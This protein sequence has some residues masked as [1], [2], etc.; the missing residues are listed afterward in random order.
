MAI[1]NNNNPM[2]PSS[3]VVPPV[4]YNQSGA[5][6]GGGI[7]ISPENLGGA[8]KCLTTQAN[9]NTRLSQQQGAYLVK[10]VRL[11][12]CDATGAVGNQTGTIKYGRPGL[13]PEFADAVA[14]LG[15]LP[16]TLNVQSRTDDNTAYIDLYNV[17]IQAT[18]SGEG[19]VWDC[20][21]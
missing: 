17:W 3:T 16:V 21:T 9:T 1:T 2:T 11:Q 13:G 14:P 18:V 15:T 10:S 8:G 5:N 12:P 7:F 6:L 19:V 20:Q 4:N